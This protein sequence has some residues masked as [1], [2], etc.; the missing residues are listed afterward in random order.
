MLLVSSWIHHRS[1]G[2]SERVDAESQSKGGGFWWMM[3]IGCFIGCEEWNDKVCSSGWTPLLWTQHLLCRHGQ[4]V[5]GRSHRFCWWRYVIHLP[6]FHQFPCFFFDV[7][8][9]FPSGGRWVGCDVAL[10]FTIPTRSQH[11]GGD[12]C[13][14]NG[15][16]NG[17]MISTTGFR[18]H[19]DAPGCR[20]E[21]RALTRGGSFCKHNQWGMEVALHDWFLACPCR[22]DNPED[23]W[24][25]NGFGMLGWC[26]P[27][28][29]KP[30]SLNRDQSYPIVLLQA[31]ASDK[32]WKISRG[33]AVHHQPLLSATVLNPRR[34]TFSSCRTTP[35]V[36]STMQIRLR[37]ATQSSCVGQPRSCF[38]R[39]GIGQ[40][41]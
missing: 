15:F 1:F 31:K 5:A 32:F 38:S 41:W 2:V 18:E 11:W 22:T 35:R 28:G 34:P 14:S 8:S 26:V 24:R 36:S 19:I 21:L 17:N 37:A 40:G 20:N 10:R 27:S 33:L 23:T 13:I 7:F 4:T 9:R 25:R 12:G 29:H 3:D 16:P 39:W 6:I 30:S